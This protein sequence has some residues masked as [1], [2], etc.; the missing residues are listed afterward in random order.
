MQA[1]SLDAFIRYQIGNMFGLSASGTWFNFYNTETFDKTYHEPMLRLG[2][3]M[4]IHPIE[5]LHININADF[6]DG[7]YARTITGENDKLPAFLDLS[8][9]AE[10]NIIPRLSLFLQL[11]NILGTKYERWNQYQAYGFNVIGGLRFKF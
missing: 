3:N 2:G 6:W 9:N 7:I 4:Y 1:L 8:A 11:N 10:Y 5:K